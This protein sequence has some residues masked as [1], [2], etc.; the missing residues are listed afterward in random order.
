MLMHGTPILPALP[1]LLLILF[2]QSS[3][4]LLILQLYLLDLRKALRI[5]CFSHAVKVLQAVVQ[6]VLCLVYPC[7]S[8]AA[9]PSANATANSKLA[10]TEQALLLLHSIPCSYTAM[11]ESAVV[12][13]TSSSF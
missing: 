7:S 4:V 6:L 3:Q 1:Y 12:L 13:R 2:S 9:S 8:S 5:C 11:A 10:A